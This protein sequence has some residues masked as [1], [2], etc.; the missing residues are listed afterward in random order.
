MCVIPLVRYAP[1]PVFPQWQQLCLS[2]WGS[3]LNT[4]IFGLIDAVVSKSLP[5][6]HPEEL[7]QVVNNSQYRD[8]DQSY[9]GFSNPTW[10]HLRERQDVFSGIIAYG[11]WGFN[12]C[13][14]RISFDK[15]QL[16][17]GPIFRDVGR[18]RCTRANADGRDAYPRLCWKRGPELWLLA[19]AIWRRQRAC[20]EDFY[21]Q[22]CILSRSLVRLSRDLNGPRLAV[23]LT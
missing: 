5:V 4:A 8:G 1:V 3:E 21:R 11:L 17:F 12:L 10:E 14:R 16:R 23:R 2:P 22:V 13:G 20:R 19:E 7:V 9:D 18:T 6:S 15:R